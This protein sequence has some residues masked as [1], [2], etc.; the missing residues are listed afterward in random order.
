MRGNLNKISVE[1]MRLVVRL[2]LGAQIGC[3]VIRLHGRRDGRRLHGCRFRFKCR[4]MMVDRGEWAVSI[5]RC[6]R[7]RA[8]A[9][10]DFDEGLCGLDGQWDRWR[11]RIAS[12]LSLVV[13]V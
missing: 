10:L 4:M 3:H 7:Y 2:V 12:R 1:A 8:V 11:T 6:I 13:V 9:V 5:V